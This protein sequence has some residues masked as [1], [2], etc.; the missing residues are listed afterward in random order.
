MNVD[1]FNLTEMRNVFN[2]CDIVVS[3]IG[4][5][6]PLGSLPTRTTLYSEATKV[7]KA[8]MD[9]MKMVRHVLMSK[10]AAAAMESSSSQ[11]KSTSEIAEEPVPPVAEVDF[12]EKQEEKVNCVFRVIFVSCW[13]TKC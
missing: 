7:L 6:R 8:T 1:I 5:R 12:E 2:D 10:K 4:G 13:G 9:N 11:S 3:C